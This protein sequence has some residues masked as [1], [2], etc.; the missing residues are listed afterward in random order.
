MMFGRRKRRKKQGP[1]AK[2]LRIAAIAVSAIA[3]LLV[4]IFATKAWLADLE[5]KNAKAGDETPSPSR[6]VDPTPLPATPV[7]PGYSRNE[8]A[9]GPD[10]ALSAERNL[11]GLVPELE[12]W[13]F[14]ASPFQCG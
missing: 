12:M 4:V 11:F 5:K 8:P 6:A 13:S 2:Y 7:N 1:Y 14:G 10:L 3:T 9:K